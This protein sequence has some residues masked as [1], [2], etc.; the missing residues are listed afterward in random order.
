LNRYTRFEA[1]TVTAEW[2]FKP[3]EPVRGRRADCATLPSIAKGTVW[4]NGERWG[5]PDFL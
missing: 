3:N 5:M 1:L 4:N 2:P